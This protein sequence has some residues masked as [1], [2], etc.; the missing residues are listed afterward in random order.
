[1]DL[2]YAQ[3]TVLHLVQKEQNQK[4]PTQ[5]ALYNRRRKGD[6]EPEIIRTLRLVVK[7]SLS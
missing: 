6:D 7:I 5:A 3:L 2:G 1:M 4:V